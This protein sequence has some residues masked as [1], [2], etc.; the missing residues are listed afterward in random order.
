[1]KKTIL[2][3]CDGLGDRPVKELERKTPLE[4]AKTPNLDKLAQMGISGA[5]NTVDIGVRPGSDTAHLALLGYDPDVYYTGRG[6]FECAGVGME[7]LPGDISFR[8]NMGTVDDELNVIDRRAGRIDDTEEIIKALNHTKIDGVEFILKKAVGH[9]VGFIMR[10]KGLSSKIRD[11]D[12]HKEGVKVHLPEPLDESTEAKFTCQVLEKFLKMS[13][14]VLKKLPMNIEREKQGKLPA[15]YFLV[16]GAGITPQLK[17]FKD[18]YGLNAVC[19]A[20]GGLYKGIAKLIGMDT[21]EVIGATGKPDSDLTTKITKLIEL[22]DKYD[23]FF[24]HFKGAD[25]L[26]E[27]GDYE[28]KVKFIEKIDSAIEPLLKI[29]DA[30][31][32]ITADHSTPCNL[33][34]HSADDV[35]VTMFASD[36]RDDDVEHFNEKECA[37]GRLGHIKGENLM[38][39]VIDLMGLAELFGA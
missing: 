9:R 16:R 19:L 34:A 29:E 20:G 6:P 21:P 31:I 7:M 38:P 8:A 2:I 30:L 32:V 25:T 3:I 22:Y 14:D 36:I 33:K 35:P 13:F 11:C 10:G 12:P 23:F 1:M 28:G 4:F 18:K 26:G 27:D 24:V 17:S 15:N 37:K 39:I 5:M